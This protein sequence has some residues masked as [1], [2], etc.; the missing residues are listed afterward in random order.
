MVVREAQRL[1][2]E[3]LEDRYISAVVCAAVGVPERTLQLY[4][5]QVFGTSPRGWH[6]LVRLH[7][8]RRLLAAGGR[9]TSVTEVALRCGFDQLGRFAVDYGRLFGEKPSDT[10]RGTPAFEALTI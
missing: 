6:R 3:R 5:R 4:F 1:L 9:S 2:L 10:L 8:A 7:R